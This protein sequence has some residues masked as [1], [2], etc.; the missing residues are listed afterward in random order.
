[1]APVPELVPELERRVVGKSAAVVVAPLAFH[2]APRLAAGG[3]VPQGPGDPERR[4]GGARSLRHSSRGPLRGC[5]FEDA[6]GC[7]SHGRR[8]VGDFD[9]YC[10]RGD[11]PARLE[12]RGGGANKMVWSQDPSTLDLH[13]YLPVFLD[14]IRESDSSLRF[15]AVEGTFELLEYAQDQL[16]DM[17]GLLVKPLKGSVESIWTYQLW[18]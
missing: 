5:M 17:L 12:P 13:V 11:L 3:P 16:P 2:H 15:I 10:Q 8:V 14:G 6:R 7:A 18:C 9:R 1:M 4:E